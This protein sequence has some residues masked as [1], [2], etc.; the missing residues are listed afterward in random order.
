M[1][2]TVPRNRIEVQRRLG[3]QSRKKRGDPCIWRAQVL[4]ACATSY[5]S[6]I[7]C[8]LPSIPD[9]ETQGFEFRREAHHG[10]AYP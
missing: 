2:S 1:E 6:P 8:M 3:E 9:K 4:L 10:N 5:C 7:V